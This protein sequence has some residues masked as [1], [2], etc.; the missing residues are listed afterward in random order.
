MQPA[1]SV[2]VSPLAGIVAGKMA[3]SLIVGGRVRLQFVTASQDASL[4]PVQL[5]V[6]AFTLAG[7]NA[8]TTAP[9]ARIPKLSFR[10]FSA[11]E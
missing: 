8:A 6:V 1:P 10:K 2:I 9:I 7:I 11:V 3:S 4:L 5:S